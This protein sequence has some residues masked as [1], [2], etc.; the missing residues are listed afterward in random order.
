M[1]KVNNARLNYKNDIEEG[2]SYV[3]KDV[4][5]KALLF[6]MV[7]YIINSNLVGKLL[8]FVEKSSFIEKN[9]VQSII[10][11][12]VFYLISINL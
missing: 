3:V 2:F 9:F 7:F 5:L 11:A 8:N 12:L 1:S 10:F 4:A 6:G